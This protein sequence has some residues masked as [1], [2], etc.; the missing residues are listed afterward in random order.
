MREGMIEARKIKWYEKVEMVQSIIQRVSEKIDSGEIESVQFSKELLEIV[1]SEKVH[2]Q[3]ILTAG[4]SLSAWFP[5]AEIRFE[6]F[7]RVEDPMIGGKTERIALKNKEEDKTNL[8]IAL[9]YPEGKP[10]SNWEQG[11]FFKD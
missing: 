8:I 1:F 7:A 9:I 11:G 6:I 5:E 4:I 2:W 3:S 10:I